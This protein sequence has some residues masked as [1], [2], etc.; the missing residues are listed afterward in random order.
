MEGSAYKKM[1][2]VIT[3]D[4]TV[5]LKKNGISSA[6]EMFG[7]RMQEVKNLVARLDLAQKNGHKMCEVSFGIVTSHF[8]YIP[9]NYT[10]ADCNPSEIMSCKEDYEKVQ[11]EKDYLNMIRS[12]S[13]AFDRIIVCVPKDMLSMMIK[14]GTLPVGKVIA[15]TSK[16][17]QN[18]CEK[19]DWTFLERKGARVGTNNADRIFELINGIC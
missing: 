13:R 4:S 16:D 7:G 11:K 5:F 3:N 9:A 10:V 14:D 12:T 19:R 15:V 2:L 8:G 17:L 1:V 6:F 18:E